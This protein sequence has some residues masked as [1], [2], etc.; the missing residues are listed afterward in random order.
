[1]AL[2]S[3]TPTAFFSY[4]REDLEFALR[5]AKD[6]KKA[7]ASVWMDKLDIRA[8]QLWE[9][10]VEDAL[11]TCPRVLVILSPSSVNSHQV[12]AEVGF[13]L[14]EHK[15]VI[16]VIYRD[17]KI[18]YRLRPI[19]HV[20]FR[21]DYAEAFQDLLDSMG[22]ERQASA[23]AVSLEE[24]AVTGMTAINEAT[25][26]ARLER[27]EREL[28]AAAEKT[29][30]EEAR[31]RQE[32]EK[33]DAAEKARREQEEQ[34]R[35]AA[36]EKTRLDEEAR[37]R[38]EQEKKDAAEK[39][40]LEQQQRE[41]Q[42]A[43]KA[44]PVEEGPRREEQQKQFSETTGPAASPRV[45]PPAFRTTLIAAGG[46]LL[47]L[48]VVYMATR[49]KPPASTSELSQPQPA[50]SAAATPAESSSGSG[51]ATSGLAASSESS[52]SVGAAPSDKVTRLKPPAGRDQVSRPQP[53]SPGPAF[54]RYSEASPSSASRGA[55][56]AEPSPPPSAAA[57][58][59]L[60][61]TA[62]KTPAPPP[63]QLRSLQFVTHADQATFLPWYLDQTAMSILDD[64]ARKLR[65]NPTANLVIVGYADGE[66][67]PRVPVKEGDIG[68]NL[69]G[70]R[71]LNAKVYLVRRHR[72]NTDRVLA[73]R[74][75][76]K[77]NC[78]D[79]FLLP[80]GGDAFPSLKPASLPDLSLIQDFPLPLKKK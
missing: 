42:A 11:G 30:L 60:K 51:S 64:D 55:P 21:G 26:K 53:S 1:M 23:A 37:E 54:S 4:S 77:S 45:L 13:A 8:G 18:P 14:D 34:E 7:G 17:C 52:S 72:I 48:L 39:A 31:E 74:G 19:Q 10:R 3:N 59:A 68:L 63:T 67:K 75:S 35:Q 49:S 79:V 33:K 6:L 43:E 47:L 61:H 25:E 20:D 56:P 78:A 15:E 36:A 9:R 65:D 22:V 44:V 32:Q 50:T 66:K 29:R 41:R 71:A 58:T 12:M 46:I 24:Q 27:E 62:P 73:K 69:A 5:L 2:P 40:R 80:V 70:A 16:P 57:P 76:G 38:Q 28:Q